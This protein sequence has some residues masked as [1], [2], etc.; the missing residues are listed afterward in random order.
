[1]ANT[2][3]I[4]D[5]FNR[6]NTDEQKQEFEQRIIHDT[7]FAQEVAFYISTH[8]VV[9]EQLQTQQKER[10]REI[11][12]QQKVILPHKQPVKQM[13]RYL[14]AACTVAI[15]AVSRLLFSSGISPKQLADEYIQQNWKTLDVAMGRGQDSLQQGLSLFNTGK[16]GAALVQFEN[17]LKHDSANFMAKKYAG[18]AALRM[19]QYDKA[20][21]YFA[22]LAR[23]TT[24]HSNPGKFYQAVV[25]FKRNGP[26]DTDAAK[27]L[28]REV[29]VN[30][31]EGSKEA[32]QWLEK[33]N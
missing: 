1:M 7:S 27:K 18:I 13:W 12:E 19:S 28:L 21:F 25:L 17:M 33:L 2:E 20:L 30:D 29:V 6:S 3:Y 31:L 9:K 10:F 26:A 32:K 4:D 24:L 23:D 15:I 11:Y 14:V 5:Y 16:P 8:N 22:A